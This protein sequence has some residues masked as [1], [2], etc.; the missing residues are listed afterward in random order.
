MLLF[1]LR[2]VKERLILQVFFKE[3]K[4][5]N[6]IFSSIGIMAWIWPMFFLGNFASWCDRNCE[7]HVS[8]SC[9]IH[10]WHEL[11]LCYTKSELFISAFHQ[12]SGMALIFMVSQIVEQFFHFKFNFLGIYVKLANHSGHLISDPF[13]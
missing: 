4:N 3:R 1:S 11:V 9:W 13:T 2:A 6:W 8:S 10:S 7:L 5:K 12:S